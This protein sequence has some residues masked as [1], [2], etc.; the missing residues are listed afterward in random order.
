MSNYTAPELRETKALHIA[1]VSEST[2]PHP[3]RKNQAAEQRSLVLSAPS[4]CIT[5]GG[6]EQYRVRLGICYQIF[7]KTY[8]SNFPNCERNTMLLGSRLD[9]PAAVAI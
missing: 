9:H 6:F 5:L 8:L 3:C 1:R 7:L 4:A 2:H